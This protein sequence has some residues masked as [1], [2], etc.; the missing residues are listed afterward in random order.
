MLKGGTALL[1][2]SIPLTLSHLQWVEPI[3]VL[4]SGLKINV[5]SHRPHTFSRSEFLQS[6]GSC[7]PYTMQLCGE[8]FTTDHSDSIILDPT[9]GLHF[10]FSARIHRMTQSIPR[11]P[12]ARTS[13]SQNTSSPACISSPFLN[14]KGN[15]LLSRILK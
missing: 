2:H 15:K 5:S 3:S 6:Q 1:P 14:T 7:R 11:S 4:E 9:S 10:K 8:T 12:N 13:C